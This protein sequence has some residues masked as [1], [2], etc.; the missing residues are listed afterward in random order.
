M[1]LSVFN[2]LMSTTPTVSGT[3]TPLSGAA[4]TN[5]AAQAV[6]MQESMKTGEAFLKVLEQVRAGKTEKSAETFFNTISA[7]ADAS[8]SFKNF[9]TNEKTGEEV[10]IV[11]LHI[12]RTRASE[13]LQKAEE[14]TPAAAE[15]PQ[16]RQKIPG[17]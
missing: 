16:K 6:Q 14:N 15:T 11:R 7:H 8:S 9:K 1:D 3:E 5:A 12:K 17:G 13:K 4:E 2:L 10:K